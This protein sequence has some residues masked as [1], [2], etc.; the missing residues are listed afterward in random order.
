MAVHEFSELRNFRRAHQRRVG[1]LGVC[2]G[3]VV[4]Q[5]AIKQR[6][7]LR[8]VTDLRTQLCGIELAH[9]NAVDQD[10]AG[11]RLV[12]AHRELL[13]SRFARTP[14]PEYLKATPLNSI[15]PRSTS[16]DKNCAPSGRSTGCAI[17]PSRLSSAICEL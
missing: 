12:E 14:A 7:I 8:H 17:T 9:V 3:Q 10:G 11:C 1:H 15:S 13:Q 4:S 2:Q 6:D 16:R 5:A